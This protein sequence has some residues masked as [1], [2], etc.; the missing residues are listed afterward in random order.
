MC[1][2]FDIILSGGYVSEGSY[3][4]VFKRSD[5]YTHP[6]TLNAVKLLSETLARA[7]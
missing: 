5:V 7:L 4:I 6:G 1:S 3:L 2:S